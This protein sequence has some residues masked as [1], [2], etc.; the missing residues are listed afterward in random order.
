[1]EETEEKKIEAGLPGTIL[2]FAGPPGVGKT[3]LGRSIAVALGRKFTHMS[4]GGMRD[5]AEIRG[6]RRTYIGAMPGRIIQ[7]IKRAGTRNPVFMLDEVDKVGADGRGDLSSAML[8][9]LAPAQNI[10]FRDHYLD[11]DFD[12]S[13][14]FFIATANQLETIPSALRDRMETIIL[15]GY[16]HLEKI[17]IAKK[18]LIPKQLR[19][20]GI[21]KSEIS[22]TREA[23]EKIIRDYTREAG[24]R[25]LEREIGAICRKSI[26][27]LN[28][29]KVSN[30]AI[31]PEKVHTFLKREKYELEIS[32]DVEIPGIAIGLAVTN[33][34]GDILFIEATRMTGKG[35]LTL[36]GQ[37]GEVMQE[38][39]RIAQSYVRSKA[40]KLGIDPDLFEKMDIHLHVP[41]GTIPKDGPSAGIAMVLALASLFSEKPLSGKLG[42]T[43]EITLRGRVLP[44][45]GLKMK[46]LAAHRAGLKTLIL[47]GRNRKDMEDIPENIK[48]EITFKFVD[49]ID[50]AMKIALLSLKPPDNL[51][52]PGKSNF[53]IR[54]HPD[55]IKDFKNLLSTYRKNQQVVTRSFKFFQQLPG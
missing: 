7:A 12:L 6:H 21:Y 11:V 28:E 54:S 19:I 9:I 32:E 46:V 34:G 30:L 2:C 41:A 36:T 25:N 27:Y 4:L 44:V 17:H 47:P 1:M 3:S 42:M 22:F 23:L 10:A 14:V 49:H 31:D 40:N 38:S 29:N 51:K 43:G 18:Y 53:F 50:D 39:S 35:K 15:P 24:V 16:T 33:T 13:E 5:E 45:G 48:D 20:N 37:L 26:I 55:L 8:D 52:T